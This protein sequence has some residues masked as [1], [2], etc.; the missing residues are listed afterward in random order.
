MAKVVGSG[1]V[2]F[3]L[4]VG[5]I[6]VTQTQDFAA[7]L[8]AFRSEPLLQR[9]A[10]FVAV[11]ILLALIPTA[12]WLSEALARQRQAA[13]ALEQRLGGVRAGVKEIAGLQVSAEASLHHL[14]RS[15]P[16]D[17]IG[18]I[19][20]RLTEAVRMAQIQESRNEIGDLQSRVEEL[21]ARQ[22]G[23]RERLLPVLDK[24]RSIERFFAE[25]DS[26]EN[27]IDRALAEIASGDDATAIAVRL[28]NLTDFVRASH[29]R[30]DE[31][32]QAAKTIV[33]LK[34]D[35]IG[36]RARLAPYA[37]A[38]DGVT[39]RIKDLTEARDKLAA[40]IDALQRTPQGNLAARVEAFADDKG[41]LDDGLANLEQQFSRLATLRQDV[42]GLSGN[43]GRALELL[44]VPAGIADD[45]NARIAAVSEFIKATQS[46]FDDIERTMATFGQLKVKLSDLQS[47]LAP[48]EARDGGIADLIAQVQDLRNRLIAKIKVIEADENGDLAARVSTFVE[49]KQELEK[50]V[51]S[52]TEQFFQLATIRSDIAGLFDKLSNATDTN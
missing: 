2:L 50:R 35:F 11:V 14:A 6:I 15:D 25:L 9:L 37:A 18:A 21:R 38:K 30:C 34:E 49:A 3:I 22:Q 4:A 12:L 10:W 7:L 17:A 36:L 24:R 31:I 51:T 27:D 1:V 46:Q 8:E 13:N 29:E 23:L 40:D 43:F 26:Q 41:K 45:A 20:Q 5:F 33:S 39:R 47:R 52:V 19:G 28:E 44:A 48:L 32:E 42:E 16:E